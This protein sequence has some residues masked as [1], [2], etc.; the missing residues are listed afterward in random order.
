[1]E[2][3]I[4]TTGGA[5]NINYIRRQPLISRGDVECYI[6]LEMEKTILNARCVDV[7]RRKKLGAPAFK[8]L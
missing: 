1:M 6:D 3:V 4:C 2:K 5:K 7:E 8:G